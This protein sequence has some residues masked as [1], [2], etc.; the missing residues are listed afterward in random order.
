[1]I[2]R[3]PLRTD[4]YH[5]HSLIRQCPPLDLNSIYAYLLIAEHFSA[6][7]VVAEEADQIAGFVSAYFPPDSPDT[8]FVWQV[9]VHERARGRQL[10]RRMLEHILE[11]P[12]ASAARFVDA[13]VGPEN[14][15]SRHLFH[16]LARRRNVAIHESALYGHVLFGPAAHD[17]EN[18]IRI[19]PL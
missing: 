16:T 13:T 11:R 18:L 9:A 5:I 15:P 4:A 14:G 17:D 6:T 10:G 7:S 12:S 1:M 3:T 19:G 8:L 2:L